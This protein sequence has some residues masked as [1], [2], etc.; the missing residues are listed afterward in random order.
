MRKSVEA[1]FYLAN[2]NLFEATGNRT[3]V[4][5]STA[6]WAVDCTTLSAPDSVSLTRPK[7]CLNHDCRHF[8][9]PVFKP[10]AMAIK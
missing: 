2:R 6:F 1:Y 8:D 7:L 4:N 5:E 9:V 10:S 3:C